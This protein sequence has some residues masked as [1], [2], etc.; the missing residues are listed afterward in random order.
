M[1]RLLLF[2]VIAL[3]AGIQALTSAS[4]ICSICGLSFGWALPR[5]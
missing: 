2:Q 4:R 3:L 1:L 5:Q